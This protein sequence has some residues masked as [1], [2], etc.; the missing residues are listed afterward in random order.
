MDLGSRGWLMPRA[1]ESKEYTDTDGGHLE[2]WL[3]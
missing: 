2:T 3:G 1:K